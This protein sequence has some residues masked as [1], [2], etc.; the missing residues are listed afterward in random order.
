MYQRSLWD[1]CLTWTKWFNLKKLNYLR[2]MRGHIKG[3]PNGE[4]RMKAEDP[5]SRVSIVVA[6]LRVTNIENYER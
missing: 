3:N 4:T 5:R 6:N 1:R 2:R